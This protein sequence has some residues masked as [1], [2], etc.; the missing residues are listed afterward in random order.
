MYKMIIVDD[1]PLIRSGLMN[2]IE[3]EVYGI[4][5]AG[6]AADGMKAYQLIKSQQPDMALLD[7][8]MPNMN[9]LELIELCSHLD[10]S[11][12]F[13]IL[14]GYNDFEYVRK[15]M[16]YGAVNY[17]LKPVDQEELTNTIMTAV[18]T[19]HD[20]SARNMQYQESLTALRNDV[21]VRL[22]NN[23]IE[24]RELREKSRF[25]NLSFHCSTMRIGILKPLF[26]EGPQPQKWLDLSSVQF[27]EELCQDICPTYAVLDTSD[28]LVLIFKDY[29]H[30]LPLDTYEELLDKCA[31]ALSAHLDLAF[32]TTLGENAQ[33]APEL[34]CTYTQALQTAERNAI[35]HNFFHQDALDELEKGKP[36]PVD[37]TELVSCMQCQDEAGVKQFIHAYFADVLSKNDI[38]ALENVKYQLIEFI[39]CTMQELKSSVL[40]DSDIDTEKQEAFHIIYRSTTLTG[41]EEKLQLHFVT[42]MKQLKQ[43]TNPKHSFMVQNTLNYVRDHFGDCNLSLKTL[44]GQLDVNAAY[45]GRQFAM[46][47]TEYFTDY[48]NRIRV[49]HAVKLLQESTLKTAKIAESVGFSNISYFFTIFKKITGG[50]P[51]DYRK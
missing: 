21:L 45:L 24:V 22:L 50:R 14:S 9:G 44:A 34:S 2:L 31:Q 29:T 37:Y 51:G 33:S 17:L 12:L 16:Q 26:P 20:R 38:T 30:V 3:W 48:L 5:I 1:E 42:L 15:A 49:A 23:H 28:N 6:E 10:R 32:L 35:L 7:I 36:S 27:C 43:N 8:S 41:L 25:V 47:T 11:P 40:P 39:I 18:S 46:E 13:I 19:L 4:E